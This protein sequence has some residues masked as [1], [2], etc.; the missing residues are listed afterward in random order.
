MFSFHYLLATALLTASLDTSEAAVRPESN[1]VLTRAMKEFALQWEILDPRETRYVLCVPNDFHA[2]VMFLRRRWQELADAPRVNDSFRFPDTTTVGQ[3]LSFNRA[4]R[5]QLEA[6]R[7]L[8][9]ARWWDLH[10]AL[11]ETDRL[12][13][14]WQTLAE[15]QCDHHYVTVRRQALKRLRDMIGDEAYYSGCMPP[16][17]P[18]WRFHQI[19]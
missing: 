14:V 16:H 6:S 5:R 1:P 4:Y 7:G 19:D 10:E 2:D 18:I 8:E 3:L 11:Q 15:A 13:L 9:L 12:H 17:V